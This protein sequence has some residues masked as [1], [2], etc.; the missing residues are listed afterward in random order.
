MIIHKLKT[1]LGL[2]PTCEEVNGFISDYLEGTLD[3]KTRGKFEAHIGDC[4]ACGR[5][6]EQYETTVRLTHD[7]GQFSPPDEL[8]EKTMAFLRKKW[9]DAGEGAD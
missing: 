1:M 9:S 8:F 6:L 4:S 7:A 3:D 2:E 5:F